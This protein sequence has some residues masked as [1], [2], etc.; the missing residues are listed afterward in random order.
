MQLKPNRQ[1]VPASQHSVFL[2]HHL[3]RVMRLGATDIVDVF[4]EFEVGGVAQ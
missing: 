1:K 3:R 2:D 4:I